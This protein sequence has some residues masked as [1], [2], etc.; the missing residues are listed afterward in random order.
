M[1]SIIIQYLSKVSFRAK[2]A[3]VKVVL[4]RRIFY[5]FTV[6]NEFTT[7]PFYEEQNYG[8]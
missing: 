5:M 7:L 4:L 8:H 1:A 3:S 2:N 6:I